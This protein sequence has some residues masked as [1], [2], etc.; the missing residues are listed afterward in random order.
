MHYLD[1]LDILRD[2]FSSDKEEFKS[3]KDKDHRQRLEGFINPV[4]TKAIIAAINAKYNLSFFYLGDKENAPGWRTVQPYVY[5]LVKGTGNHVVRAYWIDG[6]SVS[7]HYPKWRLYRLDRI[8]NITSNTTQTFD[9]PKPLYN[10]FWDKSMTLR[11]AWYKKDAAIKIGDTVKYKTQTDDTTYQVMQIDKDKGKCM[12]VVND[13]EGIRPTFI[14][15]IKNLKRTDAQSPDKNI[16]LS[17]ILKLSAE[18]IS[19]DDIVQISGK[20]SS[21]YTVIQIDYATGQ[22]MVILNANLPIRPTYTVSISDLTLFGSN[23]KYVPT[24]EEKEAVNDYSGSGYGPFNE[25]LRSGAD[26]SEADKEKI[27]EL[28]RYLKN[29]DKFDGTVYRGMG[30]DD[31]AHFDSFVKM[32]KS[33]NHLFKD[34]GFMSSTKQ[35]GLSNEFSFESNYRVSLNIKSKTGVDVSALTNSPQEGEVI[36]D[37]GTRF[38]VESY[39]LKTEDGVSFLNVILNEL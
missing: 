28:S 39:T 12:I 30:F 8:I 29:A 27:S 36:F 33:K 13:G 21:T 15:T 2:S 31:S 25:Y 10:Y 24:A 19:I 3:A 38:E 16:K 14:A 20:V 11:I 1:A 32:V 5:G 4:V 34:R 22:A 37:K 23:N 17:A 18:G 7:R 26:I 6:K 35:E 9:K